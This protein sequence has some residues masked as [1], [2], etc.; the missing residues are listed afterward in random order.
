MISP[1]GRVRP[2]P[3]GGKSMLAAAMIAVEVYVASTE[4]VVTVID[5]DIVANYHRFPNDSR[6]SPI[7]SDPATSG[8]VVAVNP[9][10][11]RSGARRARN[12][13]RRGDAESD[14]DPDLRSGEEAASQKHHRCDRLFH[15]L[16][17]LA[18]IYCTS[19]A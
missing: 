7:S 5:S 2:E 10:I 16:A 11:A 4:G 9:A 14:S 1:V 18:Q 15:F 17:L 3:A 13:D 6:R 12:H 19:A 8:R